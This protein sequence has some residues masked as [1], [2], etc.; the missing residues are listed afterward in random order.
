[1]KTLVRT[2]LTAT[3][4]TLFATVAFVAPASAHVEATGM[5]QG[6]LTMVS[7]NVEHGC[8]DID[9]TG[10]RVQMPEGAT[11]VSAE[12]PAGWTSTANST[13]IAW[14]GGPQP[15]HEE[16]AFQFTLKLA[17]ANGETVRFP[18]IESCPG[19]EI[20]WIEQTPEGGPE[21]EHPAPEIVVGATSNTT[22]EMANTGSS[23]TADATGS[24]NTKAPATMAP[25]QTPITQQ[26]STTHN[27]GLVV[28]LVVIAIIIGGAVVLYFRNRKPPAKN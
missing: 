21:P 17:Q 13:E 22:M 2:L 15:A 6:D 19:A 4:A 5:A 26:G 27:A 1:M 20:A 14:T 9:L 8:G 23:S 28:L 24:G 7:L 10:L 3:A 11:Q 12:N 16:L 25:A 18:A